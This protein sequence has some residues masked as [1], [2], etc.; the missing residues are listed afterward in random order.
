[1]Q[2]LIKLLKTKEWFLKATE[3]HIKSWEYQLELWKTS[4][5]KKQRI[6][7]HGMVSIKV[8]KGK[9]TCQHR[10]LYLAGII[11]TNKGKANI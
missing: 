7:N 8:I 5:L 4:Y 11:F 10:I 1:M 9:T 3:E 6:G 2:I